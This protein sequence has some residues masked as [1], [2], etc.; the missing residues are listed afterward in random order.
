MLDYGAM[1]RPLH[2]ASRGKFF[3]GKVRGLDAVVELVRLT[4][5]RNMLDF[6]SGKGK[7]YT[8]RR[9]HEA[10]GG[11]RPHCYDVGVPEFAKRPEGKFDG[12]VCGDMMEHI[13]PDDVDEVLADIFGFSAQREF[14]AASFVYFHICCVPS[15]HKKLMDGRDVH[16]TVEPPTYWEEK[17][18]RFQRNGLIIEARF[19]T[20]DH[21]QD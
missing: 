21:A 11:L 7:Q 8:V 12:I 5:P 16:L 13:A 18:N 2:T 10:W 1:Y 3:G 14:P 19:E 20:G 15:V 17:I 9:Q 4:S 6:G